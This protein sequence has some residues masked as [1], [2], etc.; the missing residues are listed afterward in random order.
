MSS[1]AWKKAMPCEKATSAAA[2]QLRRARA[3]MP[4]SP[5]AFIMICDQH[6]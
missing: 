1:P 5:A 3:A 4:S 6:A 2:S